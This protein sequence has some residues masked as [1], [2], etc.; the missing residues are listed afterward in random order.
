VVELRKEILIDFALHI[1]HLIFLFGILTDFCN[2][3]STGLYVIFVVML[4]SCSIE[5]L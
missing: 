5:F 1:A 3:C 2:P 4:A